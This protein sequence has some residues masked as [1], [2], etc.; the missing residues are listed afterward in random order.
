MP[1][2]LGYVV[3]VAGVGGL[4]WLLLRLVRRSQEGDPS[5]RGRD[6]S[7]PGGLYTSSDPG[8]HG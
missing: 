3:L 4:A 5:K 2:W 7:E 1:E 6:S 8:S